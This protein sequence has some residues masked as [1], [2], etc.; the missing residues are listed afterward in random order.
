MLSN[1]ADLAL[2]S[3]NPTKQLALVN[4]L[5]LGCGKSLLPKC[6]YGWKQFPV[7]VFCLDYVQEAL[8]FQLDTVKTA[9]PGHSGNHVYG[10][11]ASVC[12]LPFKSGSFSLITD[13]GTMD[14]LLKNFKDGASR[15]K[16]MLSEVQRVL[17]DGGIFMQIT[18]EDPDS[19]LYFLETNSQQSKSGQWTFS[20]LIDDANKKQECFLYMFQK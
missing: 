9:P 8:N 3:I 12:Q 16:E 1:L 20:V 5:D 19:R 14:A 7:A 18:D 15:A 17:Q 4:V 10:L 11:C 13:K 6:M 2:S